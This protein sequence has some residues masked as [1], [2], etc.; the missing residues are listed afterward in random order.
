MPIDSDTI[1]R[2]GLDKTIAAS[3]NG[4]VNGALNQPEW[5]AA[6]HPCAEA[7]PIKGVPSGAVTR[8]EDW[9]ETTIYAGTTRDMWVYLPVRQSESYR[10]IIFSDG[11]WYMGRNG[12]V[13]ATHVL[14]TLHSSGEIEPTI[15]IF[16]NP[17][18]P[19]HAVRAP[20][21][22]YD[23]HAAQRSLEYDLLSP[24]YGQFVFDEVFSFT[25]AHFGISISKDPTH[26]TL[27]GISSGG[28]AAF[29][30]AWHHP[31]QC[32]RVISHCG[33]YTDIWGGHNVPSLVRHNP[34][35]PIRIFL[36]SGSNDANT[37]FGNWA[38]ANQTM[39]S[40]L[41]WAGYDYR[42]EFGVGGHNLD[43]GG[44]VFADTL[45]WVWRSD[46]D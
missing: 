33:S 16:I 30:A 11:A 18:K 42:F 41:A 12:P 36:Q 40:A 43:H 5:D 1:L 28:I 23:D 15:A 2:L 22:S 26:R 3:V 4:R 10:V 17:G 34:R 37:P 44:A 9:S 29:T 35:K 39:A 20:I 19:D 38:L 25:E 21:E 13:R 46:S 14:D 27:A 32:Q 8:F 7:H 45:R 24:S 6:Y 31:D